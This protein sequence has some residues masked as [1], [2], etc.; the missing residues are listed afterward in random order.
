MFCTNIA[1]ELA[2]NVNLP[3]IALTAIALL[4]SETIDTSLPHSSTAL[5]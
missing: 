2:A 1:K 4:C 5:I 3:P